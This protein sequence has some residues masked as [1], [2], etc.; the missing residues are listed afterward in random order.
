MSLP[1]GAD[2]NDG[3]LLSPDHRA[4]LL[5]ESAIV[6]DVVKARG[7]RTVHKKAELERPGRTTL[8]ALTIPPG[9]ARELAG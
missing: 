4:M 7:Y 2:G 3:D 6:P 9:G 5:E 8:Y 1:E